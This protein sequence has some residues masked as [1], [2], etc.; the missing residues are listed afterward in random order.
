M[1]RSLCGFVPLWQFPYAKMNSDL[2]PGRI[3]SLPFSFFWLGVFVA[4]LLSTLPAR[5]ISC[6]Y[7][8]EIVVLRNGYG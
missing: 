5:F 2:K 1:L 7:P 3:S 4:N 6:R 8:G